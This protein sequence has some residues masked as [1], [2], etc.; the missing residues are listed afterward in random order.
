[1]NHKRIYGLLSVTSFILLGLLLIEINA[2]NQIMDNDFR[3]IEAQNRALSLQINKMIL[4]ESWIDQ[5]EKKKEIERLADIVY[6]SG[7]DGSGYA[8][9]DKRYMDLFWNLNYYEEY[10]A[11]VSLI[12][13]KGGIE[14]ADR[15]YLNK[16][17]ED[18]KA[19]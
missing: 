10:G 2:K 16:I 7:Y 5:E 12:L 9:K 1:M 14:A 3:L 8:V 17:D 4:N 19:R 11:A 18:L 13:N 6:T 15:D